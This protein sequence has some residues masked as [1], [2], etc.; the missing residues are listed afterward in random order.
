[1]RKSFGKLSS[2]A[3]T[4]SL[5]AAISALTFTSFG[6]NVW[7]ETVNEEAGDEEASAIALD[8]FDLGYIGA[9]RD[10]AVDS[11]NWS[12]WD[13]LDEA[14]SLEGVYGK[15]MT[16]GQSDLPILIMYNEKV[17][18]AA[19]YTRVYQYVDGEVVLVETNDFVGGIYPEVGVIRMCHQGGGY[20]ELDSYYYHL[21]AD[22]ED[23]YFASKSE[24]SPVD[25]MFNT[26]RVFDREFYE[27]CRDKFGEDIYE[28][29]EGECS[30]EEFLIYLAECGC[31]EE[32]LFGADMDAF[33]TPVENWVDAEEQNY[34]DFLN[35]EA[36]AVDVA[37][38]I[39]TSIE[40]EMADEEA[41]VAFI[42][43][44]NDGSNE[45]ILNLYDGWFKIFYLYNG[46]VFLANSP[47]YTGANG[48][49]V[50]TR[51]QIVQTDTL[52]EGREVYGVYDFT[53]DCKISERVS[54]SRWDNT[55]IE[56]AEDEDGSIYYVDYGY[57]REASE[58]E[59]NDL[60]DTYTDEDNLK[61]LDWISIY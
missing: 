31:V 14:G 33:L 59:Y 26:E 54:F 22:G 23:E 52:H 56:D 8:D 44:N 9:L 60:L 61:E 46:N 37:L 55:M 17:S 53:K 20:G 27:D 45:M 24:L 28:S 11:E 32:E 12:D 15:I 48:E 4:V 58:E 42:D 30:R 18:H 35:G 36:E 10:F 7:A 21:M 13:D 29:D 19:G 47:F 3:K 51:N 6:V 49:Q 16:I 50:T 2:I 5:A 43:L 25:E 34:I 41:E 38:G 57:E 1:M 40:D 39:S